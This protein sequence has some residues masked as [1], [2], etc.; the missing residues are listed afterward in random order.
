MLAL[1]EKL[2]EDLKL[3]MKDKDTVDVYK[4]QIKFLCFIHNISPSYP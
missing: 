1:K 3:S 2:M 4:R